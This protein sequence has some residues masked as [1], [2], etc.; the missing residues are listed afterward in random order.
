MQEAAEDMETV[1]GRL[2]ARENCRRQ[3]NQYFLPKAY[4]FISKGKVC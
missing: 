1:P 3:P 2:Q 4:G